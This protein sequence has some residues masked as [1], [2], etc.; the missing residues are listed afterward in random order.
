MYKQ[1]TKEIREEKTVREEEK[2]DRK[3]RNQA[4]VLITGKVQWQWYQADPTG[5]FSVY[6]TPWNLFQSEARH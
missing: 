3:R 1:F 6:V 2:Q 5:I 4:D